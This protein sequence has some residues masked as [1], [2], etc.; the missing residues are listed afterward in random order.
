MARRITESASEKH[1]RLVQ[2]VAAPGAGV[3][4]LRNESRHLLDVEGLNDLQL[5]QPIR[6]IAVVGQAVIAGVDAFQFDDV[7]VH[8]IAGRENPAG[9]RLDREK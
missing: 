3:F 4:Q 7:V 9:I 1:H 6:Q 2:Q 8:A 5:L